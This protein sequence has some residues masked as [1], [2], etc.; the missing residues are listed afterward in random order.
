MSTRPKRPLDVAVLASRR[1]QFA[2][3][4]N[5]RPLLCQQSNCPSWKR[6]QHRFNKNIT[7]WQKLLF[8]LHEDEQMGLSSSEHLTNMVSNFIF[9]PL[10]SKII[11]LLWL[12]LNFTF[13]CC[14][15]KWTVKKI[16]RARM[17]I[18]CLFSAW[19]A[20]KS[21]KNRWQK[22]IENKSQ[23]ERRRVCV[24]VTMCLCCVVC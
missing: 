22:M 13:N 3:K 21:E 23:S 11:S 19:W 17:R 10:E 6:L 18:I 1:V 7:G 24:S 20:E 9:N 16:N 8:K 14:P 5:G 12:S 4:Q 2:F 15:K